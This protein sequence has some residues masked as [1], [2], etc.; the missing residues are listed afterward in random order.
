MA[1]AKRLCGDL[2]ASG[3][4]KP[5]LMFVIP[6]SGTAFSWHGAAP[7]CL[8]DSLTLQNGVAECRASFGNGL[9]LWWLW[10]H[11]WGLSGTALVTMEHKQ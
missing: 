6:F 9:Q 2:R 1:K 10:S 7:V 8:S 4:I 3:E 11:T 5:M